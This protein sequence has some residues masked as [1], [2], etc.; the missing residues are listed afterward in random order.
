MVWVAIYNTNGPLNIILAHFGKQPT[1]WLGNTHTALGAVIFQTVIYI[2]YFMII[3]LAT[4]MNI[5]KSFYEAAQMDGASTFQQEIHITLPMSRTRAKRPI[6]VDGYMSR[7]QSHPLGCFVNSLLGDQCSVDA[8]AKQ[9]GE[10]ARMAILDPSFLYKAPPKLVASTGADA[11]DHA[12]ESIWNK[13][14]TD[15]TRNLAEAAAVEVLSFLPEV[16]ACSSGKK[17]LDKAAYAS[18]L[19]ASTIAGAAFSIT[20]TA[21]GHALSFVLSED[22]HVSKKT[23][24][25]TSPAKSSRPQ[26]QWLSEERLRQ[27][28]PWMWIPWSVTSWRESVIRSRTVGLTLNH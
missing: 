3:L 6:E 2:G 4:A 1:N 5:P 8:S 25:R 27:K 17:P 16:Y 22:W 28:P 14:A 18:M 12:L 20:G 15:A 23:N 10:H 11:L 13:N 26:I 7:F 21:A 24:T 19:R 9:E